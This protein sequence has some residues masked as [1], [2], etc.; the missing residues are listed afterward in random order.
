[1]DGHLDLWAR[2][3]YKDLADDTPMLTANRGWT[4]HGE[5]LVG[6]LVF[7]PSGKPVPVLA[8]SAR[9]TDS[10]C[11]RVTFHD[12]VELVAGA[13]HLWRLRK[14]VRRR[15]AGSECRRVE[16]QDQ[17]IQT[18]RLGNFKRRDVG[19]AE[20]LEY[21]VRQ[22]PLHPY[23]LGQWLGDGHTACGRLT[24]GD[25]E[26]FDRIESLGYRVS[27]SSRP[28]TRNIYG[29][30][31][32]LRS[33]GVLNSKNIPPEYMTASVH[34]RM[35][36]LRGL[37]DS[38]GH[39]NTRGTATFVSILSGLSAQVF[40]LAAGLGLRPRRR[41][42]R[43]KDGYEFWQVS[44]QAH[45]Q[46]NP[47]WLPRKAKRAIS[48]GPQYDV[49]NVTKVERVPSVPTRCIQVEGGMYLAGRDLVPT[50]N[51]TILTFG[52]LIFRIIRSHGD[53]APEKREVT[54]GIFSHTKPIAKGFL[55][56][57][58][59]ELETN[60]HLHAV[61][62]DVFYANPRKEAMKWTEDEGITVKRRGNPKEATIEAHGLVDGQPTSKHFFHR[63]YDDVVTIESVTTPEMMAKTTAAYEMSDN[64]GSEGG[65][66][67]M[68]GTIYHFADTY[69]QLIKRG[70]VK[71]RIHPCTKDG[72]ENF[73]ADNCVLMKPETLR[74]KRVAQGPY[75][76]GTQM[77]LNPKGDNSQTLKKEWI[78][79]HDAH[80]TQGMNVY[81][82]C[83]PANEKRKTN[84]YTTYWV[85]GLDGNRNYIWLDLLRDRFNL[86]ER[87]NALFELHS[88]WS[89]KLVV[90]EKYGMQ[91]DVQ[92]IR[93]EM[94]HRNYRFPIQ[95]IGG[96]TPKLDRIRRLIPLYEQGRM[97][98]PRGRTYTNYEGNTSD[99]ID[100]FIESEY[101]AFPVMSHDDMLDCQARIADPELVLQWPRGDSANAKVKVNTEPPRRHAYGRR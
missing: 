37:M 8:L 65:T 69:R 68:A 81:V 52:G 61:F 14:K 88:K 58:K 59:T 30:M 11:Y 50:H 100:T 25:D 48:S 36:L 24:S 96:S 75:T 80:T 74:S 31:P 35:E 62:D 5:L 72:T 4:T 60:E 99:L 17:I 87:A 57:I 83:D 78:K 77:L 22:L 26:V 63:H 70:A 9:Y 42:Y 3:H 95:E 46:R 47:F 44:F 34:Q 49:R 19:V 43:A 86:T 55:R 56:Q 94:E 54:I 18:N 33:L 90:Y 13:G 28:I 12:G 45:Q 53:D 10:E 1:M 29:I 32:V 51:S 101:A 82:L 40:E 41:F 93:S 23:V 66:F 84:D 39:C 38:D 21:P 27:S 79:R 98:L 89:P 91:A 64:L 2:E 6:D 85:V 16:W 73:S 97:F 71:A 7:S 76:F 20:P 15:I 92:H 67:S